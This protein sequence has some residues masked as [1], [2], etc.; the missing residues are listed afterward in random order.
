MVRTKFLAACHAAVSII[1]DRLTD[2]TTRM[3]ENIQASQNP[4]SFYVVSTVRGPHAARLCPGF[5]G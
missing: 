2:V 1:Y 4:S 5:T 3:C